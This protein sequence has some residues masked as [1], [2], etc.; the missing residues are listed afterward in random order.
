MIDDAKAGAMEL[1]ASLGD[2]ITTHAKICFE[3]PLNSAAVYRSFMSDVAAPGGE[4][5][6]PVLRGCRGGPDAGGGEMG[7]AGELGTCKM[8]QIG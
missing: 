7:N 1:L 2:T 8:A 5:G 3:T 6:G 4:G